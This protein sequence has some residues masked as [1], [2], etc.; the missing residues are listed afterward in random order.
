MAT[1]KTTTAK[2]STQAQVAVNQNAQLENANAKPQ[3]AEPAAQPQH[4]QKVDVKS[5]IAQ[6]LIEAMKNN[7]TPW[8]KPWKAVPTRPINA[9]THNAYKGINFLMLALSGR[10][11][12]RWMTYQQAQDKGWHVK[13]GERGTM[14][15]KVVDLSYLDEKAATQAPQESSPDQEQRSRYVLKRYFVFN[16]EQ[17]E[18]VPALEQSATVEAQPNRAQ[19]IIDA[20]KEKTGLSL[21]HQGDRACYVPSRDQILMPAKKAFFSEYDYW[22]TLLHE[23][24][25]STLHE[26]RLNRVEAISKKWGDEAYSLEELRAEITSAILASETGIAITANQSHLQ[27]HAA[28]LS[29]WIKCC[30]KDPMVIFSAA[31]DAELMAGYLLGLEATRKQEAALAVAMEPHKEWISEYFS[32]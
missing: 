28:Y 21:V 26:K 22:A 10:A 13:R 19:D 17:I 20:L 23:C 3:A 25:H 12:P 18:G 14:V 5:Q 29:S 16:A 24:A 15:V 30:E 7:N 11:D 31:K 4:D 9:T 2:H 6:T 1:R 32:K 8:Q 27:N